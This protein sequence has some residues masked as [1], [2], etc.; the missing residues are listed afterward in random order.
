MTVQRDVALGTPG[1]AVAFGDDPGVLVDSGV[2][3]GAGTTGP[4]GPTGAAGATGPGV[5]STGPTGSIG[6]TG[7]AGSTG[8]TGAGATGPAGTAGVTGPTGATGATGAGPTGSTG[9]TGAGGAAGATGP[10]G[11]G[12]GPTGPTGAAGGAGATGP[13]GSTGAGSGGTYNYQTPSTGFSVTIGSGVSDLIL[14][15]SG[16]LATGTVTMPAS[17]TDGQVTGISS[18]QAITALTVSPNAGQS[19]FGAFTGMAANG[20]GRWRYVLGVTTWFRI[21]ALLLG[22]LLL[23]HHVK[24]DVLP[25]PNSQLGACLAN[26]SNT[27]TT[28]S[29]INDQSG[30]GTAIIS[31]MGCETVKVGAFTYTLAQAGTTGFPANWGV[32]LLNIGSGPATVTTTTSLFKGASGTT[33]LTI[34]P[35]QWACPISDGT[36]YPTGTGGSPNFANPS[37]AMACNSVVNGG[38]TTAMRSDGSPA[39]PTTAVTAGSYS[40]GNFTVDACGRITLASSGLAVNNAWT[41]GQAVTPDTATSC[42]TQSAGGTMTPDF[43]VSNSCQATFG[44]GNLTGA[45]PTNVKAGQFYIIE[46]TQDGVGSRTVTWN[47]AFD[48]GSVGAPT[49]TTTASKTD[50][51]SCYAAAASGANSL[52]CLIA[53]KAL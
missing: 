44:A 40:V 13:T 22:M 15:P 43:S 19:I 31:L 2:R 42:G 51:I 46:L 20:F 37:A 26:Q 39:L 6:P 30:A 16:T 24:A 17:P 45:N 53:I 10:T 5:G 7:P 28:I 50:Q 3:P 18:T 27:L 35:N 9:P 33:T 12:V 52:H 48:W 32:C 41:K 36:D 4:T 38:A 34:Q 1:N 47:N 14:N 49:L 21:G 8:A 29:P 11:S 25:P 23:G